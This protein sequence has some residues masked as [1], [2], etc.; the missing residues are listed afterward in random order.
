MDFLRWRRYTPTIE[1][2]YTIG[3]QVSN[4]EIVPLQLLCLDPMVCLLSIYNALLQGILYLFFGA[5]PLVFGK[6]HGFNLW[7]S[8]LVFLGL[9]VSNMKSAGYSVAEIGAGSG[10]FTK[11][12]Y[13]LAPHCMKHN[14]TP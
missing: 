2:R 12:V 7:Q 6:N 4:F 5:F 11:K 1:S 10:S 3:V 14:Y 13:L 8:G 9:A